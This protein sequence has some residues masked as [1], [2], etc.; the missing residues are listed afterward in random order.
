MLG[1]NASIRVILCPGDYDDRENAA[2][3]PQTLE[4]IGR[5]TADAVIMSAGGISGEKVTDA[6]SEAVA[7]KRAMLKQANRSILVMDKRKLTFPQFEVV[8]GLDEI[9]DLVTDEPVGP[10]AAAILGKT[11]V[12]VA[13]AVREKVES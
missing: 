12:H 1:A 5:Y 6:N 7:V 9:G 3:G 13:A 4:F 8:C 10:E 11:R 2:F